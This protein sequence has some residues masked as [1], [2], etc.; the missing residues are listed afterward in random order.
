M[1]ITFKNTGHSNISIRHK[2]N[3]FFLDS[4]RQIT[5]ETDKNEPVYLCPREIALEDKPTDNKYIGLAKKAGKKASSKLILLTECAWQ[6]SDTADAQEIEVR[7][8]VFLSEEKIML[9]PFSYMY[10]KPIGGTCAYS[11]VSCKGVN[12][13]LVL[14]NFKILSIVSHLGIGFLF[15]LLA[16]PFR[17]FKIKRL[18]KDK[19]IYARL[20]QYSGLGV[21]EVVKNMTQDMDFV[22]VYSKYRKTKRKIRKNRRH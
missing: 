9:L 16:L 18:C 2:N 19:T 4:D 1:E 7:E 11:L 13:D 20:S 3:T 10:V 6:F 22:S 12:K 15:A 17:I 8:D 5:I 21:T 14:R